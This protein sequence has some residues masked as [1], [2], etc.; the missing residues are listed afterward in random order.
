MSTASINVPKQSA[1]GLSELYPYE[2]TQPS[3]CTSI[4]AE[5]EWRK[6]QLGHRRT[7]RPLIQ[8]RRQRIVPAEE[9]ARRVRRKP[10]WRIKS[11]LIDVEHQSQSHLPDVSDAAGGPSLLL[12]ACQCGQKQPRQNR[13]NGNDH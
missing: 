11:V 5:A 1:C 10:Q 9:S 4:P 13:D 3:T 6:L 12:R 7:V 8:V 2:P